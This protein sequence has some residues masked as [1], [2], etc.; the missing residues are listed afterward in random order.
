MTRGPK[1]RDSLTSHHPTLPAPAKQADL[2]HADEEE[3]RTPIPTPVVPLSELAASMGRLASPAPLPGPVLNVTPRPPRPSDPLALVSNAPVS[4]TLIEDAFDVTTDAAF[5]GLSE[6][7]RRMRLMTSLLRSGGLPAES[8]VNVIRASLAAVEQSG[9]DANIAPLTDIADALRDAV[10]S[11]GISPPVT[12]EARL[13]DTLVFDEGEVTRD[14]VALAVEANGHPVRCA[15]TYDELIAELDKRVPVLLFAEV[16]LS[17]ATPE[18]FCKTL[19]ELLYPRRVH[20]VIF[21]ELDGKTL[22][23]LARVAGARRYLSKELGPDALLAQLRTI[24]RDILDIR[25]T[26]GRPKFMG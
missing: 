3:D 14:L 15:G 21:S 20:L 22:D 17:N 19:R 2:E 10:S 1:S 16:V 12:D 24:Y 23:T 18:L 9:G 13:V 26:G 5:K 4:V 25:S 11:L 6:R 7:A 8:A